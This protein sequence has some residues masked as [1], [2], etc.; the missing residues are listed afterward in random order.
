[1][2][3]AF[4]LADDILDYAGDTATLGKNVGDDLREGKPTLPLIYLLEHGD[5][6]QKTMV[7]SAIENG[8]IDESHADFAAIL[9]AIQ[10]R[11]ALEYTQQLAD[12]EAAAAKAALAFLPESVYKNHLL[13]I[14]DYS[15]ARQV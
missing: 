1:M 6:D 8:G 15:V 14:A 3:A 2:G 7:R 4:Q 5:A 13:A 9:D 11:G 10:T 12:A